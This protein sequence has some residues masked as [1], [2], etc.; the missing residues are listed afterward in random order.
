MIKET[1]LCIILLILGMIAAWMVGFHTGCIAGKDEAELKHIRA[2][3][4]E[5][6]AR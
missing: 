5:R 6:R 1:T 2:F 3:V 4:N